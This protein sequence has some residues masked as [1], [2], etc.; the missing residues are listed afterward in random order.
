MNVTIEAL[1]ARVA[2]PGPHSDA[3]GGV[4]APLTDGEVAVVEA[5]L[6]HALPPF[7]RAMVTVV[8]D[9]GYG[10]AYGHLGLLRPIHNEDGRTALD[11]RAAHLQPDPADPHWRW[12]SSL[13]P[14]VHLGCAMYLCVDLD[15][16]DE[17]IVW[18]E[19]NP[20]VDGQPWSDAFFPFGMGLEALM[21][22]WLN[23]DDIVDLFERAWNAVSVAEGE[24][25]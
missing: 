25:A 20:H 9:G 23:G 1:A 10:F 2:Q 3:R 19:P 14:L 4:G 21:Q 17:H 24:Q 22:R 16:P 11:L 18:F 6:G 12:P 8:G 13:L 7:L 5:R 15:A